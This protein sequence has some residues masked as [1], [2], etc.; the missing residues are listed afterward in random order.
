MARTLSDQVVSQRMIEWRNLKVA[1]AKDQ[2]IIATLRAENKQLRADLAALTAKYEYIFETQ[3]A[4]IT[5]LETIVFGRR[6]KGKDTRSS[7]DSSNPKAPPR[8][9]G[10]YRRD[11]PDESDVTSHAH[12]SVDACSHCGGKLIDIVDHI[13]YVE[14][15]VLAANNPNPEIKF[16]TVVKQT[17]ERGYCI[18]CGSYTSAKDLRGQI[19]TFGPNVRSLVC[20]LITLRDH[21][22][23][24]VIQMLLD[25]YGLKITSGEIANALEDKRTALLPEYQAMKERIRAGPAIHID[26]S[27]WPIQS[28]A[29]SGYLWSMSST[30]SPEVVFKLADSR[31]KGHA[32]ELIGTDKDTPFTGVGVTDR[33][34]AYKTLFQ[35][36]DGSSRHQICWAHLQ[37]NA[38]DLTHLTILSKIKLTHVTNFYQVLAAIYSDI[39]SYK[40]EGFNQHI[41]EVQA[42]EL[43]QRVQK[44]CTP[45]PLDPKKLTNL[46]NGL[47]GY[48]DSL[49]VCLTVD[50]VPADNNRAERDIRKL[51]I[52]RKKSLGCKT[53]KGARA[54]EVLLSVCHSLYNKD[55]NNYFKN[56]QL[57]TSGA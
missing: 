29:G 26:E 32:K 28:E 1:H 43:L 41:R 3:A 33:Y 46:K 22:Y 38:K 9:P 37:R 30:N 44:L 51:V 18:P 16:K 5:E 2:K 13:R 36:S 35:N 49:F 53:P 19:A 25:L 14:D 10:S 17:I 4:R 12:S 55:P 48:Q 11:T 27:R 24:Q 7:D 40:L 21:S 34:G 57:L 45:N 8:T 39:R 52:K 50:G 6:R 42:A 54:L 56:F 23:S 31:G 15:I 47:L 20:Y